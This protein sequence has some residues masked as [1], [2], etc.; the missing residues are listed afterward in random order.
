MKLNRNSYIIILLIVINI[1]LLII[2]QQRSANYKKIISTYQKSLFDIQIRN[3]EFIEN[4]L[5]CNLRVNDQLISEL[6]VMNEDTQTRFLT[7]IMS[8]YKFVIY[9][10][11]IAC[12]DCLRTM[13]GLIKKNPKFNTSDFVII[14][15]F[16]SLSEL[17]YYKM[18]FDLQ[19]NDLFLIENTEKM[20]LFKYPIIFSS[21]GNG[22]IFP[23]DKTYPYLLNK[24]LNYNF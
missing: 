17:N 20:E 12:K 15:D 7:E 13:F 5:K 8:K 11:K 21:K 2:I 19:D 22:M 1:I 24:F 6:K 23:F 9:F 16:Y 18:E 4:V 3:E 14:S 10:P